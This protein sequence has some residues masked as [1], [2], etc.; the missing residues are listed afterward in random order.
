MKLKKLIE[1]LKRKA[2]NWFFK[3]SIGLKGLVYIKV[4]KNGEDRFIP[5]YKKAIPNLITDSGI[6]YVANLLGDADSSSP[7]KFA[8]GRLGSDATAP[9]QTDTDVKSQLGSAVA[10]VVTK[11]NTTETGDTE[12]FKC[13]WTAPAGGWSAREFALA[14]AQSGETILNRVTFSVDLAEN[15][16]IEI[17]YKV[18]VIRAT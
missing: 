14:T 18:Q 1:F 8:Y 13:E 17:T 12:V 9:A 11:E 4:K 10:A 6:A 2:R 7:T 3:G 5:V 15:D 16:V